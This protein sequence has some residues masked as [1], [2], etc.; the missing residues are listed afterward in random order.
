[1]SPKHL[2]KNIGKN[3]INHVITK[4]ISRNINIILLEVSIYNIPA[5]NCYESLGFTKVGM[6]KNYYSE[7][8]DA[9]LYNLEID[10]SGR[11]VS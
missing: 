5:R 10:K 4:I 3:L 8:E 1:M 11:M 2:R 7:G 6:R 9:I